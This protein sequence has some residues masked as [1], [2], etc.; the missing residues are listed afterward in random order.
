VIRVLTMV[1]LISLIWL[2]PRPVQALSQSASFFPTALFD[3]GDPSTF[4]LAHLQLL[5]DR[6]I[7]GMIFWEGRFFGS[8]SDGTAGTGRSLTPESFSP[9]LVRF[10]IDFVPMGT[11]GSAIDFAG[12]GPNNFSFTGTGSF[13]CALV[14]GCDEAEI[15]LA[16]VGSGGGD[17]Y[18]NLGAVGLARWRGRAE[19]LTASF[20]PYYRESARPVSPRA[21]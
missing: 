19:R 2:D 3:A 8:C 5:S 17:S 18:N 10:A 15:F 11:I 6:P 14:T 21:R 7:S 4:S 9:A 1:F 20:S 16:F 12:P 13:D